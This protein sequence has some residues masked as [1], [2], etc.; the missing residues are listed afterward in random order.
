[1]AEPAEKDAFVRRRRGRNLALA[2]GLL[3]FILLIYGV[4]IVKQADYTDKKVPVVSG[5]PK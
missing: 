1:M 3:V 4:T 2:G 5:A